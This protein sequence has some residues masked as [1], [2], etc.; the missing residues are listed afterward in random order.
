MERA[1]LKH[2]QSTIEPKYV[3][4]FID[5]DTALLSEEIPV[6][7]EHLFERYGQVT[8]QEVQEFLAT[9]LK[10]PYTPADPLVTIWNPIQK[11][12]K[13]AIQAKI[14]YTEPQLIDFALHIIRSTHDFEKALG[15]WETLS[16]SEKTWAKLK[17]Y[18]ANAHAELKKIRGPTM[19]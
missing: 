13:L 14:P 3:E 9:V 5:D 19:L 16:A 1:L 4:A 10:T 8:G 11:L 2:I 6:I 18:F 12:K 7:L 17:S 15:D